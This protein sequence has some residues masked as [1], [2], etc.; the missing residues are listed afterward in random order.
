VDV[1]SI[2]LSGF[3][4]AL[5]ATWIGEWLRRRDRFT[6]AVFAIQHELGLNAEMVQFYRNPSGWAGVEV[7]DPDE[8]LEIP[9][10]LFETRAW[11]AHAAD[12]GPRIA[13]RDWD[14]WRDAMGAYMV[15]V[16]R[17]HAHT[18]TVTRDQFS[19]DLVDN[20]ER[21]ADELARFFPWRMSMRYFRDFVSPKE[22]QLEQKSEASDD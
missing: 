2:L 21:V 6:T 9:G 13:K 5:F 8:P 15:L 20:L 12:A 18:G 1:T 7:D 10:P 4:G 19:D 14:L 16:A 3:A 11:H 22:Q 17:N